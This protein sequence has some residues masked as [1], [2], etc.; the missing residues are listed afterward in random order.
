MTRFSAHLSTLFGELPVADRPAAAAAAGFRSIESWWPGEEAPAFVAAV[1]AAGVEVACVNMDG[2]DR[3]QGERGFLNVASSRRENLVAFA[4]VVDVARQLDAA[5]VNVLVGRAVTGISLLSQWDVAVGMLRELA[6]HAASA[7]V[8]IL[9]EHLNDVD[10]P[11]ALVS[12]PKAA[13]GLV[14][15]VGSD[16]VRLLYDA[17]HAAMAG[18]D[19]VRDVGAYAGMIGH[20]QYADAPGR[21]APGTGT[22]DLRAFLAALDAIHYPGKVG[23]EFIPSGEPI[24]LEPLVA[25]Y[26]QPI[27]ATT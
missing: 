4:A 7:G 14:E 13:A 12:T 23:L 22:V 21:G 3:A 6:G 10:V 25:A 15:A 26:E 2:G 16:H 27:G 19:P 20:V 18:M 17:Y 8:T 24:R 11:G 5:S 1:H 9:I